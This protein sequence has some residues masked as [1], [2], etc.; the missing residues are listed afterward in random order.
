MPDRGH[1]RGPRQRK[2][3]HSL[4]TNILVEMTGNGTFL[5]GSFTA[6]G[7]E[8][9]TFLRGLGELVIGPDEAG[10]VI[11]DSAR[12]TVG[13][14]I[15]S[16]DAVVVG[17][18]AVPDPAD[19][20][21]YPWLWWYASHL[22]FISGSA[23]NTSTVGLESSRVEISTKA[24][25]KVGPR[26]SLVMVAQYEDLVGTPPLDVVASMRFLIGT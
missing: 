18:S 9:F 24:M 12:V 14:G 20:P 2:H 13:L 22:L 26:E 3:W 4:G 8:P 7:G 11:G 5:L 21:D 6:G 10:I 23:S 19:E 17:A 15:V 25:R 16:A 1:A